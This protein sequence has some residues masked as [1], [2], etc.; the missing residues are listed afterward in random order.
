MA[1]KDDPAMNMPGSELVS[2]PV[3]HLFGPNV[4]RLAFKRGA[5]MRQFVLAFAELLSDRLSRALIMQAIST[6]PGQNNS[7]DYGL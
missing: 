1:V 7:V 3:G 6:P 5:Y 2:R 4:A